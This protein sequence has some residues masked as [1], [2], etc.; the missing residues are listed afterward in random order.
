VDPVIAYRA[1][2]GAIFSAVRWYVPDGP[3]PAEKI[4]AQLTEQFLS[5]VA[6]HPAAPDQPTGAPPPGAPG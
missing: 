2:S 3:I 4:V 6:G 1:L 5:G